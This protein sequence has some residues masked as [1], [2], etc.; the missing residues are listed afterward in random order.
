MPLATPPG[1]ALRMS[2]FG[3]TNVHNVVILFDI[4]STLARPIVDG[5][6]F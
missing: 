2:E 4:G 3:H 1:I 5:F 6:G